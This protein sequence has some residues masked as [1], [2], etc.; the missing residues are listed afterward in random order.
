M[1]NK[2]LE[3]FFYFTLTGVFIILTIIARKDSSTT[4]DGLK[5]T[6]NSGWWSAVLLLGMVLWAWTGFRLFG[7]Y[8]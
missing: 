8:R 4:T 2:N 6:Y 5:K 7:G 3:D 1:V